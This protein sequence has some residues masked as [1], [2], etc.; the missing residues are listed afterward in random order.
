MLVAQARTP[1][2]WRYRRSEYPLRDGRAIEAFAPSP[3]GW[4]GVEFSRRYR[5][6]QTGR[7]IRH[8]AHHDS[9]TACPIVTSSMTGW[10][11]GCKI[12]ARGAKCWRCCI[13]ISMALKPST[14]VLV[15]PSG[16]ELLRSVASRL[17]GVLRDDD[18]IARFGGDE[19]VPFWKMSMAMPMSCVWQNASWMP[20]ARPIMSASMSFILRRVWYFALSRMTGKPPIY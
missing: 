8:Q 18:T 10:R 9:L 3:G 16:D 5:Q 15:M 19:F 4:C 13:W 11:T 17:S 2:L 6:T 1:L 14:T 12:A 20:F 7:K